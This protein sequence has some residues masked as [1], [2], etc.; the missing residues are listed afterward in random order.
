MSGRSVHETEAIAWEVAL[1]SGEDDDQTH[2]DFVRWR[3]ADP[4]NAAAWDGLQR[5]LTR[6]RPADAN[7]AAAMARALR[8]DGDVQG[9]RRLLR[10]GFGIGALAVSG[11]GLRLAIEQ[12]G[13]D[14]D[15][16]S[17]TGQRS[18][19]RLA[20]GSDLTLDAGTRLYRESDRR[21]MLGAGQLLLRSG[22]GHAYSVATA[23]GVVDATGATFNL[24][25]FG[26]RSL[27]AVQS[28]SAELRQ[29]D[30][31]SRRITAGQALYF[32]AGD[33]EASTLSFGA[34]T[35][36]TRGMYVADRVPM[37]QLVGVFNRYRHGLVRVSGPAAQRRISGVFAL[38][39]I[40][41]ALRQAADTLALRVS[42]YGTL[43]VTLS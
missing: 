40:D 41:A 20:D 4:A 21:L 34:V 19:I 25:R 17:G 35:A 16:R 9:R 37:A 12:L 28:G 10:A 15:W 24:G 33:D 43:V 2:A 31:T 36:W 3:E 5:R 18:A 1:R 26:E 13:Y 6:L 14:A 8:S 38:D 42:Y 22:A 11:V 39:D 7:D 27:L 23:H 32:G 30:R 29:R